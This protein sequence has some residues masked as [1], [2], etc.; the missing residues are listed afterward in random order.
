MEFDREAVKL[1]SASYAAAGLAETRA[2]RFLADV[3]AGADPRG[4]GQAWLADLLRQGDPG[5]NVQL[6]AELG[7]LMDTYPSLYDRLSTLQKRLGSPFGMP[8]W[9]TEVIEAARRS[10]ASGVWTPTVEELEFV[11]TCERLCS[12]YS[13]YYWSQRQGIHSRVKTICFCAVSG[14]T[15]LNA[16]RTFLE[17][18]FAA[19]IRKLREPK[20]KQGDLVFVNRPGGRIP[21]LITGS[22]RIGHEGVV[23]PVLADG[24]VQECQYDTIK[25]RLK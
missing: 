17:K 21:G 1:L 9:G 18:T 20:F 7:K 25:K 8:E 5:P 24:S 11:E 15:L 3:A 19:Q 22:P 23:I 14:K 13:P 4:G 6:A 10:V 16:D 12:V 2:G